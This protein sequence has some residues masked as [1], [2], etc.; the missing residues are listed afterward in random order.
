MISTSCAPDKRISLPT[1]AP[2]FYALLPEY[3]RMADAERGAPLAALLASAQQQANL[4]ED[5][6]HRPNKLVRS[7]VLA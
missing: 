2:N 7:G 3:L 4:I 1:A 5:L 6:P